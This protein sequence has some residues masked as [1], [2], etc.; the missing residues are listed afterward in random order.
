MTL[1]MST[2]VQVVACGGRDGCANVYKLGTGA[3]VLSVRHCSGDGGTAVT[4]CD[5]GDTFLVT[6]TEQ[7]LCPKTGDGRVSISCKN[8]P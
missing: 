7:G 2:F 3:S 8:K 6:G 5:I 4:C 1:T